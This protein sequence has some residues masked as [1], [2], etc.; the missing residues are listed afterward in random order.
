MPF[1]VGTRCWYPIE[2]V[3]WIGAEIID[4]NE[5]ENSITLQ[6]ENDEVKTV[7]I[8]KYDT[9]SLGKSSNDNDEVLLRNPPIMESTDDLTS[10]SYLNEPAVLHAIKERFINEK[11]IYTYSGIVLIAVNPFDNN[12]SSLYDLSMIDKYSQNRDI[13]KTY[14]NSNNNLQPHLFAIADK[15]FSQMIKFNQNQ[16]II[17]SGESGSGKTVSAKYIMRYYASVQDEST[18]SHKITDIENKILA[19][20]PIME[21]FGNAKTTRNDNSS[22]F[23]KYLS[24]KFN[25]KNNIIGAQINTY[26]LERSRLCFQPKMERNYHIFYQLLTGLD[27][28]I[29]QKLHLTEAVDYFY[30]NQGDFLHIDGVDDSI[31][32]QNTQES[33]GLINIDN[34]RQLEIFK[35]LSGI[36][37]IGNIE[38]KKV[39]NDS[40]VSSDDENLIIAT[41]LLGIDAAQFSK[42]IIKKQINTRTE[43]IISNLNFSQA[44]V[45]RDSV[46]KYIY[47]IL[48]D[49]IV[50]TI[51]VELNNLS[52]S[53]DAVNSFIGVLDIY[54]FEHFEKNSFEQ[55]CIN[56][57]NEK[58]QQEFNQHVFKLEQEEYMEEEIEWSFI[59]FNDNQQC[60][61]LIEDRVGILS[62]LDEESR[63]PAG[64]DESWTQKLYQSFDKPPT[65]KVF[66][67]PRFGQT[68]FIVSHYAHDVSYDIE[69]FIEKNKDTVSDNLLEILKN[70]TNETL[71]LLLDNV[72]S[73]DESNP[74]NNE[75]ESSRESSTKP[76]ALTPGKRMIQRKPT[77]GSLFKRSLIELMQTINSTNV[78]YIRCIKPNSDKA[79]WKFDN[80][81][82]LSQLRACGVLETIKISCA[83][84]P[85]KWTFEEFI[86]R[87]YMLISME[88]WSK[89]MIN[90][91]C[92]DLLAL[93]KVILENKIG[94]TDK[95]QIGKTKIFFRAGML[96]FME[97]LRTI[98]LNKLAV[99][100]QK[101][102][103]G[104]Y[105][106]R[107]YLATL[108][109]IKA[110]QSH[111]RSKLVRLRI[112]HEFEVNAAVL[113]QT[114]IRSRILQRNYESI[115]RSNILMQ[116]YI[117]GK[118][119]SKWV[120]E[121]SRI[122]SCITIQSS[123]RKFKK[124][125]YFLSLK[126]DT[127]IVQSHIRRKLA[128]TAYA[129]LVE[130]MNSV[131]AKLA[132]ELIEFLNELFNQA[133]SCKDDYDSLKKLK[134]GDNMLT[135]L[136]E[137]THFISLSKELDLLFDTLQDKKAEIECMRD[138]HKEKLENIKFQL[139]L[140]EDKDR[141]SKSKVKNKN[142]SITDK[143]N[144]LFDEI[145]LLNV[146]TLQSS[147]K[148][149]KFDMKKIMGLGL[150][151]SK[152]FSDSE[153]TVIN[154]DITNL[155]MNNDTIVNE[156][157]NKFLKIY[158]VPKNASEVPE[159]GL[160]FPSEVI[161]FVIQQYIYNN[162][163]DD[164]HI[165]TSKI[166]H[167]IDEIVTKSYRS[168]SNGMNM[169]E[170]FWL[171]NVFNVYSFISQDRYIGLLPVINNFQNLICTIYNIWMKK[172]IRFLRY[173]INISNILL[174]SSTNFS[175][176]G[177]DTSN[178]RKMAHLLIFFY[179]ILDSCKLYQ[180]E[181][182]IAN[183]ILR[184]IL[185]FI[186]SL[187]FNDL[188]V[189]FFS[190]SWK[191]GLYLDTNMN[192]I[193]EWF[194]KH[195][196]KISSKENM[197]HLRQIS[198]FLQLRI[199][200]LH[201]FKIIQEF[202]YALNPVQLQ[203]MLKKY[204]PTNLEKP[205]P[206]DVINYLN[207]IIKRD[208]SRDSLTIVMET[209]TFKNPIISENN[210]TKLPLRNVDTNH[211]PSRD[212]LHAYSLENVVELIDLSH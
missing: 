92:T 38:I 64:S 70:T 201:D 14:N 174:G 7:P 84:F 210:E 136:K 113:I 140:F 109:S 103:R 76:G 15:A 152:D 183:H 82:V 88:V 178:D 23:G 128:Q 95:Y 143:L 41:E 66:S 117:R 93:T 72:D 25:S 49:W 102:I 179:K 151:T 114:I 55:F 167:T 144:N 121:V 80:L 212:I 146:K 27:S 148:I 33:L 155:L 81:M 122:R 208:D 124:R 137:D 111:I 159:F 106:R 67:K 21:A 166:C 79:P 31:E 34:A 206:K 120:I 62:L 164:L 127:I 170:L 135:L 182:E 61:A 184:D 141:Q 153:K 199:T 172:V 29:K 2:E 39:R 112:E 175:R 52:V 192:S 160:L 147:S 8:P 98:K 19:T 138:T 50:D 198:K 116:S 53:N 11:N 4:R 63:L 156:V 85:S 35:I 130:Q 189:K 51:N 17:V 58:L 134:S 42:W 13:S 46:A 87:Y 22:R 139:K 69:G 90:G 190:L 171:S 78:H 163:S 204:K 56:Y 161:I 44:V 47:S 205:V 194:L 181:T 57:A 187:C 173:D 97:N 142:I 96:A 154:N 123:I 40:T 165:F 77:L 37:H 118:L 73:K 209:Q 129:E 89:Y 36:L 104:I 54:G 193:D 30:L 48:F 18:H 176:D 211:T 68:K 115:L 126:N 43:K 101:K 71:K 207:N 133:K 100:V 168:E 105:Y 75:V 202:C 195:D 60:I 191:L 197:I 65:N 108:E 3:G 1:Q 150:S 6:L 24:I 59:E 125:Y 158:A 145:E 186:N 45:V 28:N 169:D 188:C 91:V 86:Q 200:N 203:T 131:E 12:L 74:E 16:T 99:R 157:N 180:L 107:I 94:D 20:N 9:Q 185:Q 149:N 26:L 119:L 110:L 196:I 162:L 132:R 5:N 83:G 177:Q 10:L 32:F